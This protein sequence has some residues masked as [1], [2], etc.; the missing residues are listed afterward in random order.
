MRLN[1]IIFHTN[2]VGFV[3]RKIVFVG[4]YP[5]AKDVNLYVFFRNLVHAIADIGVECHVVS[6]VSV[7]KYKASVKSIPRHK[8]EKTENGSIV[9]VHHPRYLS[10]SQKQIGLV[11]T[12]KYTHASYLSAALKETK[13]LNIKFDAAYGHFFFS[14][15]LAAAHIGK[16]LKIPSFIAYGES[17]YEVMVRG[18]KVPVTK[19]SIEALSGIIS[20]STK[21]TDELRNEDVYSNVPIFTCPNAIDLKLFPD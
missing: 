18:R 19:E 5:N 15:G 2:E 8:E 7:T 17:S 14:G 13:R 6:P 11:N 12:M 21:N 10:F 3:N 1:T 20:V 16:A 9:Y 4:G